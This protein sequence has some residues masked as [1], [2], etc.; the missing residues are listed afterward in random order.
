MFVPI[1]YGY[2]YPKR[3]KI[4]ASSANQQTLS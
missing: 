1:P 2:Q 4:N 3:I